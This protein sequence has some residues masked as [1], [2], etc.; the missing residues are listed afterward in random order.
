MR[1]RCV[2]LLEMLPLSPLSAVILLYLHRP[3]CALYFSHLVAS[4]GRPLRLIDDNNVE[5]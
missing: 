2:H 5:S 3:R 1:L 4:S